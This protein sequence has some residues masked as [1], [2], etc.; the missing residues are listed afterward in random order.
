VAADSLSQQL[1]T[2]P[3]DGELQ[4][5][6]QK[7]RGTSRSSSS[8][9]STD[10]ISSLWETAQPLALKYFAPAVLL[11]VS[12]RWLLRHGKQQ[13]QQDKQ[14]QQQQPDPAEPEPTLAM[15]ASDYV[16]DP[17]ST[18]SPRASFLDGMRCVVAE[19]VAVPVSVRER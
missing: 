2:L 8:S 12:L 14:Q 10:D 5:Q 17:P 13:Q 18:A 9:S 16:L 11:L 1:Q 3:A 15:Y 7:H 6:Q 4:R 19:N